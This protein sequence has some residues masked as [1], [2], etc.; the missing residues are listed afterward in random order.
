M[1]RKAIVCTAVGL[2]VA[3]CAAAVAA[4]Q[5]VGQ[6]PATYAIDA[7]GRGPEAAARWTVVGGA[8]DTLG[9]VGAV[10]RC[11]DALYVSEPLRGRIRRIDAGLSEQ[12]GVL[13]VPAP[14]GRVQLPFG[15]AAD[16]AA[17]RL[18]VLDGGPPT[19]VTLALPDARLVRKQ[20]LP[21][22]ANPVPSLPQLGLDARTG[23]VYFAGLQWPEG[24][25]GASDRDQARFYTALRVGFAA[26]AQRQEFRSLLDPYERSCRAWGACAKPSLDRVPGPGRDAWVMALPTSAYVAVYDQESRLSRRI[27]V[28]SPRFKSDGAT[29]PRGEPDVT[30][31]TANSVI[32]SLFAFNGVIATAHATMR[33]PD[34]WQIGVPVALEVLLNLHAQDGTPLVSDIRLPGPPVGRDT[35]HLYV[36]DYGAAG[37]MQDVDRVDIVALSIDRLRRG[38]FEPAR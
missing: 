37:R 6:G 10:S 16:C 27:D 1:T 2:A 26:S 3:A 30:W 24:A 5:A 8:V 21:A 23:T 13:L 7:A 25:T 17:Q 32:L 31:Q 15:L 19:L 20:R 12:Q 9:F 11:G 35:D 33:L 22:G 4:Q 14:D 28:R 36:A 29:S 18:Y 34:D 38:F